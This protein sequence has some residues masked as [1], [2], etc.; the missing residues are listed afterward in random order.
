[1]FHDFHVAFDCIKA[2]FAPPAPKKSSQTKATAQFVAQNL[3][4]IQ[5]GYNN[6]RFVLYS[7]NLFIYIHPY[8]F[9]FFPN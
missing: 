6:L 1:M 4:W 3:G 8:V 9:S 7:T 5:Y 2:V